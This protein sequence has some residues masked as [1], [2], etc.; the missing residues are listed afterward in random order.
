MVPSCQFFRLSVCLFSSVTD[1]LN[2][3][4]RN[5]PCTSQFCLYSKLR[6]LRPLVNIIVFIAPGSRVRFLLSLS[7]LL[8]TNSLS[9]V[10][11]LGF[12]FLA[13]LQM[14]NI[15]NSPLHVFYRLCKQKRFHMFEN[16]QIIKDYGPSR[17]SICLFA[18]F[19]TIKLSCTKI[20]KGGPFSSRDP[21]GSA[22]FQIPSPYL[23][24]STIE[25]YGQKSIPS[26]DSLS[27][28]F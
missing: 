13:A 9:E 26:F 15:A 14:Q 16:M 2:Q 10:K 28:F 4:W 17:S 3:I 24:I 8:A 27:H 7:I 1:I 23:L 12:L 11:M 21:T 25:F 5:D 18:F 6:P 22:L 19:S 20:K